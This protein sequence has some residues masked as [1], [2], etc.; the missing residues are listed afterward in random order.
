MKAM[1][2]N[3]ICEIKV[4]G[5]ARQR[6]D[7]LL[8]VEPLELIDL[9]VPKPGPKEILIKVSACGV[10]RTELD[11]IEGRISPP[12]LPVILGHQPVGIV[13]DLGAKVTKFRIGDWVG[14]AWIYSSCGQCKFCQKGE[15]NLCEQFQGT[16]CDA[17]GGYAEYMAI[18]ED[19]AYNIPDRFADLVQAAP[20]MCSGNIFYPDIKRPAVCRLPVSAGCC[21]LRR[22][23]LPSTQKSAYWI[24]TCR[25]IPEGIFWKTPF[26]SALQFFLLTLIC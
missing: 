21:L 16:G 15:E 2:L 12:K 1:V 25:E 23:S 20:L 19:F 18:S 7:L 3:E 5:G 9:P 6:E 8:K 4:E 11:Q 22:L 13:E 14:A 17:N 26:S 24:S 10:C